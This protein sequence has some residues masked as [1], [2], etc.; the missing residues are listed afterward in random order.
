[1]RDQFLVELTEERAARIPDLAELNKLFTAW[2]E[3]ACH[4]HWLSTG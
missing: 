2:T 1:M 4:V 3:T